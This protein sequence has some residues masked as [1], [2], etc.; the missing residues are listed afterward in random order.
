M[1]KFNKWKIFDK[2]GSNVALYA[3][4]F[5]DLDVRDEGEGR[6]AAGYFITSPDRI[7]SDVE[8]SNSGYLYTPA[9][10]SIYYKSLL[11]EFEHQ[12]PPDSSISYVD[13]SIF[14]PLPTNSKG[15]SD[16]K[17][18]ISTLY[19]YPSVVYTGTI[20]MKPVSQGLVE[21]EHLFILEET[22]LGYVRPF[23][24]SN[25]VLVLQMI[26]DEDQIKFFEVDETTQEIQW[27]DTISVEME[28]TAP[29]VD[30]YYDSANNV[31]INTNVY[32]ITVNIGFRSD[33]D[34]VFKRLMR[35]Y[36]VV[37]GDYYTVAEIEV[38][39]Q[40]I[41]EDER[42]RALLDNFGLPDP[43]NM[44]DV[45]KETDINEALPD[46]KVI[47]YKSKHMVLEHSQ[48][49]PYV[50]TYKALIN[51]IKWLGYDDIYFREWFKNV[52]DGTKLSLLVPYE[53]K[54][55]RDTIM[56]FSA[57]QRKTL[58][59]LN[60]LSMVYCLTRETDEVDD[61]GVP[62]TENCY[63]YNINEVFVKLFS[64]KKWLENNIIGVNAR[65]IDITGE[66]VYFDRYSN[67][68]Y[69]TGCVS[70]V[71]RYEE[72]MTPYSF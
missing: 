16:I 23:D 45:F 53:A 3:N 17:V 34:G 50:G 1:A 4:S 37:N 29:P 51:S 14:N 28:T 7:I 49:M 63:S 59:K 67:A 66:G 27:A 56:M 65:I 57:E 10:T 5:I 24:A 42:Y 64:L 54:D 22:S 47:N 25:N 18:D 43:K 46:Y 33:D 31:M 40:A 60:Q 39:A 32:P 62:V 55:R 19:D 71:D 72:S 38:N 8:I 13:V 61:Y 70:Y 6:D 9:T 15:I 35:V 52:K 58:K 26:G 48:I 2:A 20:Y 12:I 21:T 44:M 41:A 36:H 11:E 69:S 30:K 68:I